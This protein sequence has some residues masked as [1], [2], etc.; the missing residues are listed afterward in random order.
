[1]VLAII[2]GIGSTI[3]GELATTL[4]RPID[5]AS[6]MSL[7]LAA[8]SLLGLGVFGPGIAAGLVSGSPQLGAGAAAGIEL[9]RGL[10]TVAA[11]DALIALRAGY[12]TCTLGGVDETKFPSN[13]HWPSDIPDN[14]D[15]SS[16]DGAVTVC[17]QY[18]RA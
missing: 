4:T 17:L 3:F 9:T 8:L 10:R 16:I 11:T 1:M 12:P 13:Y 7:L 14:L 6:A 2:I 18:V 5:I 15:W